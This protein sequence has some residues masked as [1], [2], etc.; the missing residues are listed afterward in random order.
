MAEKCVLV[1][2]DEEMVHEMVEAQLQSAGYCEYSFSSPVEALRFYEDHES[3]V[4]LVIVDFTLG[5]ATGSDVAE[6]LLKV[7]PTLPVIL[8][9]GRPQ[10]SVPPNEKSLFARIVAKP[11]TKSELLQAIDGVLKGKGGKEHEG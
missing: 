8:I 10:E 1:L 2:D 7:N 11:F 9:T 3:D 6:R 4:A 5:Q